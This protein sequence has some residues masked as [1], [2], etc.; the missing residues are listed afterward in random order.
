[1]QFRPLLPRTAWVVAALL[2]ALSAFHYYTAGFGLLPETVHRGV[3]MAFVIG[4]I[5]L[6]FPTFRTR[7]AKPRPSSLLAPLGIGLLD[8]ACAL[9]AIVTA[10]YVPWIFHDL[11]FRVG[12]PLTIDCAWAR[13]VFWWCWRPAGA[14]SVRRSR[15]LQS[16]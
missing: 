3:H 8:W 10:L 4:L 2:L 11:Q 7:Q 1:M 6:V 16:R 12:N 15:S 9:A 14:A 5:Y 13:S